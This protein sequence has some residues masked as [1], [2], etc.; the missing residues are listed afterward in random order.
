F[1]WRSEAHHKPLGPSCGRPER[2][3]H[4]HEGAVGRLDKKVG[5]GR[6]DRKMRVDDQFRFGSV[7]LGLD[8]AKRGQ[9][10]WFCRLWHEVDETLQQDIVTLPLPHFRRK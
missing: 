1:V 4:R 6:A 8:A 5:A 9:L 2:L 3:W 7:E 10:V